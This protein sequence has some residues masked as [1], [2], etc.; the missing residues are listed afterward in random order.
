MEPKAFTYLL[1]KQEDLEKLKK[2]EEEA[3]AAAA[4]EV[5][6]VEKEA[7]ERPSNAVDSA[8]AMERK[9]LEQALKF[10]KLERQVPTRD[11][12]EDVVDVE[13]ALSNP[14][15]I[16]Y[17]NVA[18]KASVLDDFLSRRNQLK[19]L[20]ERRIELKTGIKP[21]QSASAKTTATS[22]AGQWLTI[23]TSNV[24]LLWDIQVYGQVD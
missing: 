7:A 1:N 16:L 12:F 15:R 23:Y 4:K 5:V 11:M 6:D 9:K 18:K 17:P 10:A 2:E 24:C 14:S 8:K 13:A 19:S 20:E 22:A 3:A 21:T